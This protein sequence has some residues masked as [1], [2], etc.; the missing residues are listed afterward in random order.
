MG[1]TVGDRFVVELSEHFLGEQKMAM[2]TDGIM[3]TQAELDKM[4]RLD[5]DYINEH[6]G[7]FQDEAYDNGFADGK[8]AGIEEGRLLAE[9]DAFNEQFPT[10]LKV[11]ISGPIT[12]N[13]NATLDF[14]K[15]EQRLREQGY[16]VINP[17]MLNII[18]NQATTKHSEYMEVCYTLLDL[19]DILYMMSGW[20]ESK[21]ANQEY[22]YGRAK[23]KLILFEEDEI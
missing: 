10:K 4:E 12:N 23:E 9:V 21:G 18:L 17:S 2:S 22:G 7:E 15:V 14:T 20:E 6:F 13:P 11:Y 5:S 16:E 1:Y 19:A 3:F 8:K